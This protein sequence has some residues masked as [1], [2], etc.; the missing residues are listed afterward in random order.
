MIIERD[1]KC[2]SI[3]INLY[4]KYNLVTFSIYILNVE[5]G[6]IKIHEVVNVFNGGIKT[7]QCTSHSLQNKLQDNAER[8]LYKQMS[9]KGGLFCHLRVNSS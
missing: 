8:H 6:V 2:N 3:E 4:I 1:K 9:L 5:K 7:M